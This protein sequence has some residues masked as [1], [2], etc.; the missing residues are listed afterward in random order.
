MVFIV[1]GTHYPVD[2]GLAGSVRKTSIVSPESEDG[3]KEHPIATKDVENLAKQPVSESS[4]D[5]MA[6]V[7]IRTF[8]S[9]HSACQI[10]RT[11]V[12]RLMM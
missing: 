1:D 3:C 6:R 12:L 7:G 4:Q 9:D 5:R 10:H 11:S 8:I 2:H